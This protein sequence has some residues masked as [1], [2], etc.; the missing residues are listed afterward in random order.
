MLDVSTRPP[1]DDAPDPGR[2]D[3]P[4]LE[5]FAARWEQIVSELS[6]PAT[7]P[8]APDDAAAPGGP[9]TDADEDLDDPGWG[10]VL[11]A[12]AESATGFR[13]WSP[14][15][16]PDEDHFVPPEPEPLRADPMLTLSWVVAVGVPVVLIVVVV[17]WA[18]PATWVL[19]A[20]AAAWLGAVAALLWRMPATR[21][22]DDPGAVV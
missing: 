9:G 21:D 13:S 22:D 10:D 17:G 11:A 6:G 4:E 2:D 1:A 15:E 18:R 20:V 3:E 16:D 7:A 5:E 12:P 19:A 14:A 8:S